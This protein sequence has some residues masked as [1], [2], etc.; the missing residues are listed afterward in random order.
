VPIDRDDLPHLLRSQ[1]RHQGLVGPDALKVPKKLA[2][3]CAVIVPANQRLE[4]M[5]VGIKRAETVDTPQGGKKQGL[6]AAQKRLLAV[7]HQGTVIAR[8]RLLLGLDRLRELRH[9]R[10]KGMLLVEPMGT[11]MHTDQ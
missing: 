2:Q 5:L 9:N 7:M 3:R 4:R 1:R 10:V 11:H 8:M 6:Q